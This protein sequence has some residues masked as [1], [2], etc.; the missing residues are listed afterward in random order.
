MPLS[1]GTLNPDIKTS[2]YS[3]LASQ[4]G[5]VLSGLSPAN[6]ATIQAQWMKLATAI[7]QAGTPIVA[8]I[9]ADALVNVTGVTPGGGSAT[10]TIT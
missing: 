4:F 9:T 5:S 6:V 1:S 2:V 7:S 10:G 3:G 8:H